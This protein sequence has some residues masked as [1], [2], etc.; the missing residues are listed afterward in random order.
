MVVLLASLSS[1]GSLTASV[2]V[3]QQRCTGEC[4]SNSLLFAFAL[5]SLKQVFEET[6]GAAIPEKRRYIVLDMTMDNGTA[7]VIIPQVQFYFA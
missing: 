3:P 7:D 2:D 4:A 5:G 1:A 6:M